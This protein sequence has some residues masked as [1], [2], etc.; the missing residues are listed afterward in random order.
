M[1]A[2]FINRPIFAWVIAIAIMLGGAL[3]LRTLPIA[4]YPDVALPQISIFGQ[5]P[6]ASAK[7]VDQ[8]VT[9]IIEQQMKGLDNLLYMRSSSDS[10][11][12]VDI[13]FTFAA[14][15][16]GDIA[17]V[18]VQNKLQQA[19]PQLPEAVQRQ[20]L[21]V[22]KAVENSFM[23]IAFYTSDDSLGAGYVSD[24]VAGKVLDSLSR[25]Q[26]VGS[27]KRMLL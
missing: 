2:F 19:M 23:I 17:Q 7:V 9:Q 21:Q 15:T 11:G 25:V 6:G 26:G 8:S 3:C 18:Q 27:D 5:Y 14:G 16:D 4:Q 12:N 20:G 10:F 13:Y 24:Y 22:T 1:G